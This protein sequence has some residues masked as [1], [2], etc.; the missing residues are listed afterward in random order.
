MQTAYVSVWTVSGSLKIQSGM[1]VSIECYTEDR[2][3]GFIWVCFFI[4]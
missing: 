4:N 1:R 3:E 2:G